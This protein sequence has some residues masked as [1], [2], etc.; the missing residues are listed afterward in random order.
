MTDFADFSAAELSAMRLDGELFLSHGALITADEPDVLSTR[1]RIARG[2]APPQYIL[3]DTSA[4]WV[5]QATP[6]PPPEPEFCQRT[7]SRGTDRMNSFRSKR[8]LRLRPDDVVGTVHGDVLSPWRTLLGLLRWEPTL[9]PETV[10][11]LL[12]RADE[13]FASAGARIDREMA[14]NQRGYYQQPLSRFA[15][16]IGNAV[17]VVD[18]VDST[19]RVEHSVEMGDI[20][21]FEDKA[22]DCKPVG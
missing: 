22:A 19:D 17:D 2:F 18:R 4:A 20:A 6:T 14:I 3:A 16:G 21:H 13:S 1:V 11:A 12:E 5:W 8:Y 7:D 9:S 10:T 15:L